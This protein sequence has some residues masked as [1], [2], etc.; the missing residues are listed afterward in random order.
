MEFS[1]INQKAL[2][3]L[4]RMALEEDIG[5]GDATTLAIVPDSAFATAYFTTRQPCVCCGLPV[6]SML[7]RMLD[8]YIDISFQ[9]EDGTPCL[10]GTRLAT[11]TGSARAILTGE[12]IA[13]NFMQRLSGVATVTRK[14]VEAL[15]KSKTVI[16]D[17][18]K[19]TPG[20]RMLE[21][22][23]VTMG[24]GTNHRIGLYDRVMIKDNHRELAKMLGPDSIEK[25]VKAC[26]DKY[27]N[28]LI[29]VEADSMNDVSDAVDAGADII[30]LDNM[31]NAQM[32]E[33]IKFINGAAKTEASGGITLDRLSS[34]ADLGLDYISVGA[35]THSAPSVDIGLDM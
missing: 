32:R 10:A 28:L 31:T 20:F 12:R 8:K 5:T 33:A 22:Y 3:E 11:V 18:R 19:T 9:V 14:Y 1:E 24:G 27:P 4:C 2:E 16:L 23:A 7:Y 17:T 21:K 35:L 26:R 30:L 29:E 34:M 25:A 13:L 6:M 15:G